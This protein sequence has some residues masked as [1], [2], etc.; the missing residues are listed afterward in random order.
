MHNFDMVSLLRCEQHFHCA[1]MNHAYYLF[2]TAIN[3]QFT[4][5]SPFTYCTPSDPNTID[6]ADSPLPRA[7]PGHQIPRLLCPP[8]TKPPD[9]L[10]PMRLRMRA[11][12]S[13]PQFFS[14]KRQ[15]GVMEGQ[16]RERRTTGAS[17]NDAIHAT[18]KQRRRRPGGGSQEVNDGSAATQNR[19]PHGSKW[20]EPDYLRVSGRRFGRLWVASPAAGRAHGSPSP[21]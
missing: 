9:S 4:H 11:S 16:I 7:V 20:A 17:P 18:R 6:V 3:T 13:N 12:G 10:L 14:E 21:R 1:T 15:R 8:E 2:S 5:V 19:S